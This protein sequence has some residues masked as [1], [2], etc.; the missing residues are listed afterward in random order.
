MEDSIGLQY[1]D[2][3]I[4]RSVYTTWEDTYEKRK[5]KKF[6]VWYGFTYNLPNGASI[7]YSYYPYVMGGMLKIE[8][9]LPHVVLG[10]N[11][12]MV[13]D[14]GQAIDKANQ[15]LPVIDGIPQL[16]LW[17]GILYRLDACY[18]F[19]VGDLV[20]WYINAIKPLKIPNRKTWQYTNN[21]VRFWNTQRELKFYDKAQERRDK[22]DPIG[23]EIAFGFLRLELELHK[24][25]IKQLTGK[26]RPTLRDI[27]LDLLVDTLDNELDILGLL[28]RSIGTYD[29]TLKQLCETYDEDLGFYYFGV[30]SA[31]VEHPS[32][33]SVVSD[34]GMHPRTLD[35]R[36]KKVLDA[37]LPLTMTK[38]DK[39]LPPLLLDREA[40]LNKLAE[41]RRLS[42]NEMATIET[43]IV[44]RTSAET[45]PNTIGSLVHGRYA[46]SEHLSVDSRCYP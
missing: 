5:G 29:T 17:D 21:G 4:D 45:R 24:N 16:N 14:I 18:N 25:A 27:N 32:R 41:S 19:Q 6:I 36:L 23:A 44:K 7:Q 35:R 22:G 12:H 8:F 20:P 1:F 2:I 39:P 34:S 31:C 37:G 40:I 10:S 46:Q 15:L 9:S 28:G 30:L 26:E 11:I 43:G 38:A 42:S 13:Y 3:H 33:E